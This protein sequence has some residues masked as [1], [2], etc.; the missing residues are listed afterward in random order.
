MISI[1]TPEEIEVMAQAGQ[2][3]AKIIRQLK[4]KVEPGLTTEELDKLAEE[5]ILKSGAKPA[6]KGYRGFPA[7][8]CV[9]LNEQI[10]HAAPSKRELKEGD[11]LSLDLGI[12][13]Q[14]FY[15]DMAVTLS[16]GSVSPETLKLIQA[17]KKALRKAIARVKPG[18][19][20]GDIS[21][22]IQKHIE[23]DGFQ[24]VRQ[25]CGHGI[26]RQLHE[27]PDIPNSGQRHK[28]E[29][30]KTGMVLALEPMAVIG[31]PKI[32]KAQDGFGYQ[33]ADNS[34]SAHFEHTVAVTE[35]GPRILTE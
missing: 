19:A 5:L 27:R 6:F 11:I 14:G 24:V 29:I 26:G 31:Q 22:A 15:S 1:K 16:I 2:I 17:T 13:Y 33:T 4:A 3:L 34:L 28:G 32:K 8:L 20:I 12:I 30:L 18:K 35:K 25:L 9:S 10:V 7:S 23:A 21:F